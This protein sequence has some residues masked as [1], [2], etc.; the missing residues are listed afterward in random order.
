MRGAAASAAARR[1]RR[2][3]ACVVRKAAKRAFSNVRSPAVIIAAGYAY[4]SRN[5]VSS[6]GSD[7]PIAGDD[8][9]E[10]KVSDRTGSDRGRGSRLER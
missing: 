7:G 5:A 2:R 3:C 1:T 10:S 8:E 9:D 4:A 6:S